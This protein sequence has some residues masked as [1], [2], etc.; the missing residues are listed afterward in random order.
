MKVY[1]CPNV[2]LTLTWL[3]VQ[4]LSYE[5][6]NWISF[7]I[8][9]QA[10]KLGLFGKS[11]YWIEVGPLAIK[12]WH[13]SKSSWGCPL[14]FPTSSNICHSFHKQSVNIQLIFQQLL[15]EYNLST[16]DIYRCKDS[17]T[18]KKIKDIGGT[19][20]VKKKC[21]ARV[22]GIKRISSSLRVAAT[23]SLAT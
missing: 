14:E 2:Y 21:K 17:V 19:N 3:T 13:P 20:P 5:C 18:A 11:K 4:S 12:I 23:T 15:L 16:V 7:T 22:R 1:F 8:D 6:K 9:I 10:A